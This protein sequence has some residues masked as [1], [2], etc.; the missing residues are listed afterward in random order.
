MQKVRGPGSECKKGGVFVLEREGAKAEEWLNTSG[1]W[2]RREQRPVLGL[3]G[4]GL[5]VMGKSVGGWHDSKKN[6]SKQLKR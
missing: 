6:G 3:G 2:A 4:G 1:G 5:P